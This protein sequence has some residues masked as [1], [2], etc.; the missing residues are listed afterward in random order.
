MTEMSEA[1]RLSRLLFQARESLDMWRDVVEIRTGKTD[2]YTR[3]LVQQID[4]YRAEKG[5]PA[6]GW[7]GEQ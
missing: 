2:A 3:G 6:D 4:D 7:G 5:W 1:A